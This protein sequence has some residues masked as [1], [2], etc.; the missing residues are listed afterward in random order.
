MLCV[1]PL[2]DAHATDLLP[3]LARAPLCR[4][5]ASECTVDDEPG[6]ALVRV[7]PGA[8]RRFHLRVPAAGR[9]VLDV[10]RGS[11]VLALTVRTDEQGERELLRAA[12]AV[13]PGAFRTTTIDLASYGGLVV[14]VTLRADPGPA[15]V[16]PSQGVLLRRAVLE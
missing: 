6:T 8:G 16:S 13:E 7:P 9:L 4:D 11:A 5:G 2:G 14:E 1:L 3:A 15:A 10:A 12:E